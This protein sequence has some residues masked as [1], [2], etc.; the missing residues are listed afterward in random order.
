MDRAFFDSPAACIKNA[1][2]IANE[3]CLTSFLFLHSTVWS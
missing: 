3:Q 1:L 2:E